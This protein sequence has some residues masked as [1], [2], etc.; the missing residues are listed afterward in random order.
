LARDRRQAHRP[1]QRGPA[2]PLAF[3]EVTSATDWLAP[4]TSPTGGDPVRIE[5][6]DTFAAGRIAG[7]CRDAAPYAARRQPRREGRRHGPRKP[8]AETAE[9]KAHPQITSGGGNFSRGRQERAPRI[10]I[11]AI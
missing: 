11:H 5:I 9:R 10:N 1:G 4:L 8:R 7:L 3:D 6:G 2:N